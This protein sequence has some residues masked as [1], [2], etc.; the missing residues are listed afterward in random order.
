MTEVLDPPSQIA[1]AL[2][3]LS[4]TMGCVPIP[5]TSILDPNYVS[6]S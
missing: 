5:K 4:L 6:A 1:K 2:I 3:I